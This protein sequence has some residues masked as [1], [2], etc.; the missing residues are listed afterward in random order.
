MT[1]AV[2]VSFGLVVT[3]EIKD[4]AHIYFVILLKACIVSC[5]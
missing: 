1:K 5:N 3:L 4:N 2:S